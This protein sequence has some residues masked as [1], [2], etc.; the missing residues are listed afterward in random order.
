MAMMV[1]AQRK[2]NTCLAH[3]TPWSVS[4]ATNVDRSVSIRS[5]AAAVELCASSSSN[6]SSTRPGRRDIDVG[7]FHQKVRNLINSRHIVMNLMTEPMS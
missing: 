3:A 1:V 6:G 4:N 2:R 7:E 5:N